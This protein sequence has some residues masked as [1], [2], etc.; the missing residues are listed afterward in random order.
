VDE[1]AFYLLPSISRGYAPKGKSWTQFKLT[2][3]ANL[4]VISAVVSSGKFCYQIINGKLNSKVI[5]GFLRKLLYHFRRT[6]ILIVWDGA[7]PHRSGE[8]KNF[9]SQLP[10]GRILLECLPAYCPELNVDE[11]VWAFA[12]NHLVPNRFF[13]NVNELGL[14]LEQSFEIMKKNEKLIASFF[15]HKDTGFYATS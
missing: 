15:F 3:R 14:A 1:S 9:L 8:L 10:T 5:I 11:Q 7:T 4:K 2:G 13:R 12:K 6:N